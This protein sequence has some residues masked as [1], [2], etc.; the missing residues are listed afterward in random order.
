MLSE[1][2]RQRLKAV[3]SI[4]YEYHW[5]NSLPEMVQSV[6]YF[7]KVAGELGKQGSAT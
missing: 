7:N 2:H 3:F 5:E 4:E 6:A 1:V